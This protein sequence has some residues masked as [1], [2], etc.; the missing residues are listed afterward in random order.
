MHKVVQKSLILTIPQISAQALTIRP[1]GTAPDDGGEAAE[2]VATLAI[3]SH[4]F[5][6]WKT[7]A[8]PVHRPLNIQR[9]GSAAGRD[10]GNQGG[11]RSKSPSSNSNNT[12][13]QMT[14]TASNTLAHSSSRQCL[15]IW[16]ITIQ[17]VC[18]TSNSHSLL[19]QISANRGGGAQS[20]GLGIRK[21]RARVIIVG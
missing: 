16:S 11:R 17:Q 19:S 1:R 10:N 15:A 3:D 14:A 6:R 18:H 4:P 12:S 2:A 5:P 13:H 21:G 9:P 20:A 8:P 7:R